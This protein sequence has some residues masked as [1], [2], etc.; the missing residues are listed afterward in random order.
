MGFRWPNSV[1]GHAVTNE[2]WRDYL[3]RLPV[4]ERKRRYDES[5]AKGETD[6]MIVW[7]GKAV[8]L[9]NEFRPAAEVVA[10]IHDETVRTLQKASSLL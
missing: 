3:E 6:R 9:T 5:R 2:I 7:A 8:G 1:V 10:Q 4:E